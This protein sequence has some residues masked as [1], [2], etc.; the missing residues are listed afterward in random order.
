MFNNF[1]GTKFAFGHLMGFCF[2]TGL[3]MLFIRIVML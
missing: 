3:F 1:F 2:L